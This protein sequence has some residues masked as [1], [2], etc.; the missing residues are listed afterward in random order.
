MSEVKVHPVPAEW[1]KRAFVDK[2]RYRAMYQRS[3]DDPDGFW[4]GEARRIDW[5]KPF[6]KVKNTSFREPDVF[7]KWFEDGTL[8][9]SANCLDRHLEKRGDQVAIL[10]EGDNPN[11]SRKITYRELHR[12]VCVF[13]NVLL[14]IGVKKGDR[15]TIYL[16]MIPEIAVAMLACS[17]IAAIHSVVFGGFSPESLGSRIDDCRSS[18]V[19]TTDEG[20]RGGKK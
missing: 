19:V 20:V 3:V 4:A 13:A 8:N 11:Q 12:E 2:A 1:K 10:W 18:L 5:I 16:P 15:V 17:P 6:T 14:K 7:I 9:V